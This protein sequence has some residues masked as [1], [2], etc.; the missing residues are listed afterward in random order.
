MKNTTLLKFL[1]FPCSS[2]CVVSRGED[3]FKLDFSKTTTLD[4]N[5]SKTQ[6]NAKSKG[7]IS[8]LMLLILF[9]F[10]NISTAQITV[11]GNPID[12]NSANFNTFPVKSYVL[13]AYGTGQ[14]D[15]QFTSSKDFFLADGTGTGYLGWVI[16]QTKAKNDIAN[17]AAVLDNGILYFAGDRTSNN[18]DAQIGFWFFLNG[19]A[20]RTLFTSPNAGGDFFPAHAPGDILVLAD[21]TGGGNTA[22]VQVFRWKGS[23][24]LSPGS[25]V[26]PNTNGNLETTNIVGIVAENNASQYPIPTGWSFLNPIYDTNEFYEG[27]VDL[28]GL[29]IANT[30]FSSFL[31]EARSSQSVTASLDDFAGGNFNVRPTVT[32]NNVTV[33]AG[34]PAT[35]TATPNGG[36]A[37]LTYSFNGLPFQA[38]NTFTIDPATTSGSVT[39][40]VKGAGPNFC[41]SDVATGTLTVNPVPTVTV[42]SPVKCSNDPAVTI[43]ATPNPAGTYTYVWQVPVGAVNPGNVASFSA[44]VGGTY[45]VTI[46]TTGGTNCSG[47]G[48]GTLTVNPS[49]TL[50]THNP[51]P[52]CAPLTVDLTAPAVTAGSNLQGGTLSYWTNAGATIPLNNPN[53]VS[54]SGTY[55]IKVTTS[56]N[57]TDI[58][59]VTVTVIPVIPIVINCPQNSTTSAC[60]YA[61]QAALVTAFNNWVAGFTATGGNGTLVTSGLQNLS[62]PNLCAGGSVTVNFSA[63]DDCGKQASCSATFTI[64]AAP[65]VQVTQ[66]ANSTT[67]ACAYAD[68]AAVNA[69]FATWLGGFTVSGGCNPQG[70]YG[71]VSA[72]NACG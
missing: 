28:S 29:N 44:T 27:R 56:A 42:N 59:P 34:Q 71:E 65:A 41:E 49:P 68:Q 26:V 6:G 35:F 38:S 60:A 58:K 31:L 18:G 21:F 14:V 48:S 17:A 62:P 24:P 13:D 12:W 47:S 5:Y 51:A 32:I 10:S 66:P 61:D 43:T 46:T 19:T 9:L 37:P 67:S 64:T 20:P 45:T 2:D 69:A 72:P 22:T 7:V 55:Y 39:V 25:S 57:C 23:G 63:S 33:C 11:D 30:C 15:N 8:I 52:V 54:A 36:I 16:G 4:G 53:A 50:V 70:S 3:G 1:E 40:V